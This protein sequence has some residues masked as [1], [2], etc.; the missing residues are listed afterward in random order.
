MTDFVTT[1][2]NTVYYPD[3]KF[4]EMLPLEAAFVLA[5]EYVHIKDYERMGTFKY[6]AMYLFPQ[7]LSVLSL[8]TLFAFI[9]PYAW[10]FLIFFLCLLPIPS[11]SRKRIEMKGYKMSIYIFYLYM[12]LNNCSEEFIIRNLQYQIDLSSKY[13]V[14]S[15]YYF[16]W[17]FGVRKELTAFAGTLLYKTAEYNDE[18]YKNVTNALNISIDKTL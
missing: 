3:R 5:H 14:N 18:V 4:V 16:M 6:T 1:I 12:V 15:A 17:P 2:G 7:I 13:F 9:T 11:F 8:L 10:L